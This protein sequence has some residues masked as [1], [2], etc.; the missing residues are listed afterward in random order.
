[1]YKRDIQFLSIYDI[2]CWMEM[3]INCELCSL[4]KLW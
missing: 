1:M 4:V 2:P 3:E